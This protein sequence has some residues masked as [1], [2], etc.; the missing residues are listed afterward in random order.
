MTLVTSVGR[1]PVVAAVDHRLK[2]TSLCLGVG[3]GSRHDPPGRGGLAHMLEHLLM[4]APVGVGGPL[5][6]HIERLGGN[7]N[8]ETGLEQMLFYAQVAAEDAERTL[9][10]LLRGVLT[11]EPDVATLDAERTAVLQELAAAEAD[12]A[13]VVQDAFLAALFPDHPLGR[14]VGGTVPEIRGLD[15]DTVLRRHRELFLASP[16]A[17]AVVG[18]GIPRMPADFSYDGRAAPKPRPKIPL[19]PVRAVE[20]TW[21]DEFGWVAVG[22]RSPGLDDAGRQCYTVL[23]KLMGADACSL[24][25]RELRVSAG[26]A[27]SFQ[28]W[29]RGYAEAGAWR[30]LIGVESGNGAKAVDVVVREL[31]KLATDGPTGADLDTARRRARMSLVL[32]AETPLEHARLLA[33]RALGRPTAWDMERELSLIA[34]VTRDGI[35]E[36]AAHLRSCLVTVVRPESR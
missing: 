17:L 34:D 7:A 28:A 19:G 11:P 35:R 26:L 1:I 2:T 27:Y 15:V 24:L 30:V 8:A 13:D 6:Q 33:H 31:D 20:P 9:D 10:L 29:D 5:V 21:P 22:G 36:A 3:Y 32:D 16:M 25:Y 18:P 12:P 14:P 23:A 4:S